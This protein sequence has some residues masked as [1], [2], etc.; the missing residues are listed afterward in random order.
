MLIMAIG[1]NSIAI[2]KDPDL[3]P[4]DAIQLLE[5][6]RETIERLLQ[7]L[8]HTRQIYGAAQRPQ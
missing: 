6:E 4:E 7:R 8:H 2:A 1:V 5:H 3:T